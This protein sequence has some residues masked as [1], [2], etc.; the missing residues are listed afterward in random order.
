MIPALV[1]S[2]LARLA[3]ELG[4]LTPQLLVNATPWVGRGRP[5]RCFWPAAARHALERHSGT[6][7]ACHLEVGHPKFRRRRKAEAA[8]CHVQLTGPGWAGRWE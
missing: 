5:G 1:G 4:A 3:T 7:A 6:E 8:S 2:G